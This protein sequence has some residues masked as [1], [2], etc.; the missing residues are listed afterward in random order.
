[1]NKQCVIFIE[2]NTTGS[3]I[4][5]IKKAKELGI[6][7]I[8]L[9]RDTKIYPKIMTLCE[10]L[11]CETNCFETLLKNITDVKYNYELLGIMS[12]SEYYIEMVSRVCTYFNLPSNQLETIELCRSKYELRQ[13]LSS[14][15]FEQPNFF[16]ANSIEIFKRKIEKINF[17]VVIKPV[18]ESGSLNVK[19][20]SCKEEAVQQASLILE[21]K[22]NVRNQKVNSAVL[23]EIFIEGE[24]YSVETFVQDGEI[25][26]IGITEKKV[27]GYPYFVE[28]GHIFPAKL[29]GK[30]EKLIRE[31]AVNALKLVGNNFGAMHTE[32]KLYRG[33]AYLI[34]INPRLA[35]G[36]IPQIV[37]NAIG[38]D[39]LENC[40]LSTCNLGLKLDPKSENISQ[41]SFMI[42]SESGKLKEISFS[43]CLKEFQKTIVYQIGKQV[44]IPQSSYDRLGYIISTAA[45]YEEI[46]DHIKKIASGVKIK[47]EQ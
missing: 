16:I 38:I 31:T 25:K 28:T 41:I 26:C 23:C 4:E 10:V 45:N 39:L 14:N 44:N 40:L 17:P 2:S 18:S 43:D 19:L 21:K 9:A 11:E 22:M 32:L 36:M 1:M 8:V 30:I 24:E 6:V 34:E 7:P 47:I 27:G 29:E 12:T 46:S 15:G 37:K 13:L 3:G 42:P 5:I 35:G 33:K 20:C